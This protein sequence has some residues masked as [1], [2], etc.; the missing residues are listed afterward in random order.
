VD[1][2]ELCEAVL[3]GLGNTSI[4][5]ALKFRD[6]FERLAILRDEIEMVMNRMVA[7]TYA[8]RDRAARAKSSA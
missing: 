3:D 2:S 1:R 6:K 5:H 4:E 7:E 8:K